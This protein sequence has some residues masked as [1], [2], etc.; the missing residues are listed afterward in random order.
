L[1]EKILV[2]GG[3]DISTFEI[4]DLSIEAQI[5][6]SMQT[7]S[8]RK[9]SIFVAVMILLTLSFSGLRSNGYSS[10]T[11]LK[12]AA[13]ANVGYLNG[14][15]NPQ[16]LAYDASN[17]FVYVSDYGNYCS[18]SFGGCDANS[19]DRGRV[20]IINS[21]SNKVVAEVKVGWGA[22]NII[23]D[24]S[25]GEV[26]VINQLNNTVSALKEISVVKTIRVGLQNPYNLVAGTQGPLANILYNPSNQMVYIGNAGTN[27]VS[28]ISGSSDRVTATVIVGS[29]PL[30]ITYDPSN[31]EVYVS[32]LASNS[33]SVIKDTKVVATLRAADPGFLAY[34]PINK[35]MYLTRSDYG[36]GSILVINGTT[37]KIVHTIKLPMG[38][39]AE[40]IAYSPANK[41]IY[42]GGSDQ[43]QNASIFVVSSLANKITAR[44]DI[45]YIDNY[46]PLLLFA[47]YNPA[48]GSMYFSAEDGYGSGYVVALSSSNKVTGAIVSPSLWLPFQIIYNPS[49]KYV[50]AAY[51]VTNKVGAIS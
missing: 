11:N 31:K 30:R 29:A 27:T 15:G 35:D 41:D 5:H 2:S 36:N 32:N 50:Y 40:A 16:F 20:V 39:G 1:T 4:P 24:P 51:S 22:S 23:Y 19:I 7:L 17:K 34:D 46:Y 37:N 48:T 26:Y 47:L 38:I 21:S 13:T 18:I 44:V 8:T 43:T 6:T 12:L 3:C 28:I 25:N 49:N 42:V 33:I 9:A 45:S 14:H 10:G